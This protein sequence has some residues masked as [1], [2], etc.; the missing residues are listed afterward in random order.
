MRPD[1]Q[2]RKDCHILSFTAMKLSH[3]GWL[4][5][6]WPLAISVLAVWGIVRL[7]PQMYSDSEFSRYGTSGVSWKPANGCGP[8]RDP[9]YP[10]FSWSGKPNLVLQL[11]GPH[12]RMWPWWSRRSSMAVTAA[13]S[14]SSLPQSSTGVWKLR[15]CWRVH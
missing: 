9:F 7:L 14:P 13:L 8:G 10:A 3:F 12:F 1:H 11:R 6:T 15:A 5:R 4:K 2:A